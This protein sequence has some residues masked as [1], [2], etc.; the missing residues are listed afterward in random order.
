MRRPSFQGLIAA[1]LVS[2]S[3][4]IAQDSTNLY[5]GAV[6]CEQCHADQFAE[7]QSS[8]HARILHEADDP[9]ALAVPLP[10]GYTRDQ[11]S[12]VIGGF[13]WESM[14]L[15]RDG[16][17]I[18]SPRPRPADEYL[19]EIDAGVNYKPGEIVPYDCGP[20]HT[21]GFSLQGHQDSLPGISGTWALNSVQCEA[22]H[23]PGG[24]HAQTSDKLDI[25]VDSTGCIKCHHLDPIHVIPLDGDFLARYTEA[26]Q[27]HMSTMSGLA[28]VRCHDPHRSAERSIFIDCEECH[29][30]VAA[31][32]RGSVMERAGVD[33][34]DCHMAR[35]ELIAKG[36]PKLFEGDFRS[37]LFRIEPARSFPA[38]MQD[39]RRVNPGY[40]SVDYVCVRCHD[41][42]E[43]RDWMVQF[44]ESV[45]HLQVTTDVKIMRFQRVIT[46]I[47]FLFAIVAFLAALLVKGWIPNLW[48]KRILARIHR[49]AAWVTLFVAIFM[50]AVC[51]YFHF[52]F[53]EP[54]RAAGMGLFVIHFI[55]GM[56]AFILYAGKFVVARMYKKAWMTPGAVWGIALFVFWLIQIATIAFRT[57]A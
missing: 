53:H 23:G 43:S 2:M 14:F 16:Y 35:A 18:T 4:C 1:L 5:V 51:L 21:T 6:V 38:Q 52:P 49:E 22:C 37:H 24:R 28:C 47:G 54:S 3:T 50:A 46:W 57:H 26:N 55:N 56:V 11:I 42:Y 41:L 45:H 8:G 31:R 20:C 40:L 32:Y 33:C 27:L 39:G 25:G 13:K 17:V 10:P 30:D 34:E 48:N 12:Y 44:S 7:W 29:E 15:D 19:L 9:Q 36:N